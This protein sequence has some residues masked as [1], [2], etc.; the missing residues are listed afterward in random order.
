MS[1]PSDH[2]LNFV[3]VGG[4]NGWTLPYW[5]HIFA[6]TLTEATREWL[7]KLPDGQIQDWNDLMAK[8]SQHFS[9]EKKHTRDPSELLD[10]VR[11]NNESIE[12]FISRFNNESLNIGGISEDMLRGAF[13]KN[14][15]SNELIS[16]LT[17]RDG[18]PKTW[19]DIMSAA[20]MFARME[21]TLGN[22]N[23]ASASARVTNKWT[24]SKTP[25]EILTTENV[26]FN[27]PQPLT[28]RTFLNPKKHCSF[29]DDIGHNKDECIALKGEIEA[30]VKSGKLG[31]LVKKGY[32]KAPTHDN[33]GPSKKQVKD[34]N[35]HII[36]VGHKIGGKRREFDEE[37]WKN[38]H[39]FFFRGLKEVPSTKI[40]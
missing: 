19:N 1:D 8:F 5:C 27:K 4:V 14:V 23:K 11:R 26:K 21:K 6:L 35:V 2:L 9:Q 25:S 16:T 3:P 24:L 39:V 38:E 40:H 30:A 12:D 10:V 7:E 33:Q 28:K 36:Q 32:G 22:K 34:L 13:C 15:R 17:G 37:E 18:M 31:H 20:K 29:H